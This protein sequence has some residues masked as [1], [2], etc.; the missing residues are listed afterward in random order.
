MQLMYRGTPYMAPDTVPMNSQATIEGK[1]HGIKIQ[2]AL[3][4]IPQGIDHVKELICY[5]G[6]RLVTG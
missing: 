6:V 4:Q 1:Y 2:I 5:R 3:P